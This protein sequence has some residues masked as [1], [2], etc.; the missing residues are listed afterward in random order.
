MTITASQTAAAHEALGKY[1][2]AVENAARI[3]GALAT[4]GAE[5]REAAKV[6]LPY[7]AS[8]LPAIAWDSAPPTAEWFAGLDALIAETKAGLAAS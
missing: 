8:P 5:A 1:R 2:S 3:A 4:A 6:L 7:V